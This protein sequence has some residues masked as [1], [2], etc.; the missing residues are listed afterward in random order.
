M[1]EINRFFSCG[2]DSFFLFGPRG[3]GKSTWIAKNLKGAYLVDLLD[4]DKIWWG[5]FS[6]FRIIELRR[7]GDFWHN[8]R[9]WKKVKVKREE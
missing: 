9:G 8:M 5:K 7:E 1:K 6:N 3:T 2:N 4:G